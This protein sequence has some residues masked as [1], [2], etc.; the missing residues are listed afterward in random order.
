MGLGRTKIIW[1]GWGAQIF[2]YETSKKIQVTFDAN[3]KLNY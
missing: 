1:T 3:T 2:Y